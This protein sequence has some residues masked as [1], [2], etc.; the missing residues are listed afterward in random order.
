M[1]TLSV[2]R[3]KTP[4]WA[5]TDTRQGNK[6]SPFFRCSHT[7][8]TFF[9]LFSFFASVCLAAIS[10]HFRG[11][12]LLEAFLPFSCQVSRP[13]DLETS[14][15]ILQG[16]CQSS[17]T[18]TSSLNAFQLLSLRQHKLQ[19]SGVRCHRTNRAILSRAHVTI[20]AIQRRG[21]HLRRLASF[22][23]S[24]PERIKLAPTR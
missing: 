13:R 9:F 17:S 2:S 5:Q 3:A 20:I 7:A 12:C 6:R 16:N 10:G 14:A 15:S 18:F 4:T 24:G 23:L 1:L 11:G 22:I 19:L 8:L 21:S